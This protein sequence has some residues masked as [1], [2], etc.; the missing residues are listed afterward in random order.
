MKY[1]DEVVYVSRGCIEQFLS[2]TLLARRP[3]ADARI[4][5]GAHSILAEGFWVQR[6]ANRGFHVLVLSLSGCG[7]FIMDDGTTFLLEEGKAFLSSATGQA[8]LERPYGKEPWHCIW[9]NIDATS[10]WGV[11]K[12]D[13]YTI[14]QFSQQKQLTE[15]FLSAMLEDHYHDQ[16]SLLA[17]EMY[18]HLFLITLKRSLGWSEEHNTLRY[19]KQFSLLWQKVASELTK[20]WN[21]SDLCK[22]MNLS[23]AHLT[24]LCL[25]LYQMPPGLR[26]RAIKMDQ[27]KVLIENTD[28]PFS[29]VSDM[30]GFSNPSTFSTAFKRYY[31]YA[32]RALRKNK[33]ESD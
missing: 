4:R 23:K 16:D 11:P 2:A 12:I 19:R 13:D 28:I 31:G 5:K 25:E 8:H 30:V 3:Y 9:L 14:Y 32:P 33:K 26:V 6:I 15:H 1:I 29:T 10:G 17:Q 20:P 24:R 21:I 7:E 18:A 22:E 27:A